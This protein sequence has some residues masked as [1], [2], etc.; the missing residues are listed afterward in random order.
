V[1]VSEREGLAIEPGFADKRPAEWR[2]GPSRFEDV[3]GEGWRGRSEV[4]VYAEVVGR[5]G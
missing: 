4:G 5:R 2:R 1:R 3:D